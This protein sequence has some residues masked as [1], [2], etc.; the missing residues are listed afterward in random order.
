MDWV[1]VSLL[2][3]VLTHC[4]LLQVAFCGAVLAAHNK[5][6][7]IGKSK[8]ESGERAKGHGEVTSLSDTRW[9]SLHSFQLGPASRPCKSVLCFVTFVI[10]SV[11][12]S[13]CLCCQN[14]SPVFLSTYGMVIY[15]HLLLWITYLLLLCTVNCVVARWPNVFLR[16]LLVINNDSNSDKIIVTGVYCMNSHSWIKGVS[17]WWGMDCLKMLKRDWFIDLLTVVHSF[18]FV[19]FCGWMWKKCMYIWSQLSFSDHLKS[20]SWLIVE[21][22]EQ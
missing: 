14:L 21:K 20:V 11:G 16:N 3:Y 9:Y 7:S 18:Q 8:Q 12:P 4:L 17:R 19:N 5:V 22:A 1:T 15:G 10:T 2:C 13:I 6:Q